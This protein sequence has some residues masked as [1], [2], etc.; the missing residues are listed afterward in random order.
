MSLQHFFR[1][2][3]YFYFKLIL[4][5]KF[6]LHKYIIQNGRSVF[7]AISEM[8]GNSVLIPNQNVFSGFMKFKSLIQTAI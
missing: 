1:V 3:Q 2:D 6:A 5:G 8:V 4:A 7:G